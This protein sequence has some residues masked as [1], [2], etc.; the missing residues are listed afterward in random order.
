[1]PHAR[2]VAPTE[3]HRR[4][5]QGFIEKVLDRSPHPGFRRV[6]LLVPPAPPV[7]FAID[8]PDPDTAGPGRVFMLPPAPPGQAITFVL[9]PDQEIWGSTGEGGGLAV[10]GVVVE[11]LE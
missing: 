11:Y 9:L 5:V 4:V 1:M 8:Q 7:A 6:Q 10:L 3:S 2:P